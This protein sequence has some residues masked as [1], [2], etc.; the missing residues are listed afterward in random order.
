MN[1]EGLPAFRN[2]WPDSLLLRALTCCPWQGAL[3]VGAA[4][5]THYLLNLT[6]QGEGWGGSTSL[7]AF[8]AYPLGRYPE[9]DK[10]HS[11]DHK[12]EGEWL[13]VTYR[14]YAVP[15]SCWM[16]HSSGRPFSFIDPLFSA[17]AWQAEQLHLSGWGRSWG[18]TQGFLTSKSWLSPVLACFLVSREREHR[19]HGLPVGV[20]DVE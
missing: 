1:L 3:W 2:L 19:Q 13:T 8:S 18:L 10:Q 6:M 11:S 9:N 5:S 15:A 20:K 12:L 16:G 7:G 14:M 4:L 17:C